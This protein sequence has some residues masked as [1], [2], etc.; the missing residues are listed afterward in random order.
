VAEHTFPPNPINW[1]NIGAG[2]GTDDGIVFDNRQAQTFVPTTSGYLK[3]IAFNVYRES[4]TDADLRVSITSTVGGQPQTT[5]ESMVLP[6]SLVGTNYL[7]SSFLLSNTFSHRVAA[8]GSV[9]LNAGVSYAL[10]FSSDRK[11]ANYRIHGDQSGY[12]QGVA[13]QFQ[14]SGPYHEFVGADLVFRVSANPLPGPSITFARSGNQLTLSW[15]QSGFVLEE[16]SNLS[17]DAGWISIGAWT[18]VTIT[19]APIGSKFYRL[20]KQ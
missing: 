19:I 11:E 6:F 7:D 12:D 16:N 8:S 18:P 5:L 20:R 17:N 13:L 4:N 9:L 2:I 1:F 3:E 10:V 14:N 15:N